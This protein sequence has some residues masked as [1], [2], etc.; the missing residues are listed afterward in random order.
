[1]VD[2]CLKVNQQYRVDDCRQVPGPHVTN[3][4]N[5]GSL[6]IDDEPDW[7]PDG[8]QIVY[9]SHPPT[10][11]DNAFSPHAELY[12]MRMNP[13]GTPVQDDKENPKQL[14]IDPPTQPVEERGP[15]WSPDGKHIVYACKPDVFRIC[16]MD[17]EH[18]DKRTT[19]SPGPRRLTPSWSPDGKQI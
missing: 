17:A 11:S 3:I 8:T 14:T 5:N 6:T 19:V 7:S 2:G 16:A 15:R 10:D 4:T 1:N 13:D 12:V 18:V 9:V